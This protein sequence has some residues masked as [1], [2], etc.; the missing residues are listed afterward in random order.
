MRRSAL[1]LALAAAC[2]RG[3]ASIRVDRAVIATT[4]DGSMSV[5]YFT[6]R[7]ERAASDTLRRVSVDSAVAVTM[8]TPRQHALGV[9]SAANSLTAVPLP[10]QSVVRFAPGGLHAMVPAP[11]LTLRQGMRVRMVAHLASG[12]SASGE[13]PV[14]GY[15]DLDSAFDD[16]SAWERTRAAVTRVGSV[17]HRNGGTAAA[18]SIEEG[19]ELYGANGCVSCHGPSGRGDGPL[20]ATLSPRPRD[21]R[22]ATAFKLGNDIST[23][24]Q[25]IAA[26]IPGGGAM[27]PFPHLTRREREAIARYVVS[28]RA[29]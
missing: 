1:A 16:R 11:A 7:N 25:T 28:L 6:L 20:A 29:P 22:N 2:T 23:I 8:H 18:A 12:D 9:V 10:A 19:R 13:V 14:V 24:A 21:F 17:L 15:A 26:G 3:S 4:P 5:L 27:P